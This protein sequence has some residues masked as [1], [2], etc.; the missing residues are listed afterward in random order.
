MP[1]SDNFDAQGHE[2]VVP[3]TALVAGAVGTNA[4][5]TIAP[6]TSAGQN[7]TV[8]AVT[9]ATDRSG[10]FTLN[11]V[12]GGGAQA[13]GIVVKVAFAAPYTR[14]PSEINVVMEDTT[15]SPVVA[16]ACGID[17]ITSVGFN[18]IVAAALTTA[19]VYVVSY[20]VVA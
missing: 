16:V 13:A 18:I 1:G 6:T 5:G 8:T 12:T 10:T 4:V 3:G 14:P 17:S 11:P 2:I 19:H 9:S 7:P 20:D 15:A